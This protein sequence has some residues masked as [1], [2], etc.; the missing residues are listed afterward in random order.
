MDLG[1]PRTRREVP[2]GLAG[3]DSGSRGRTFNLSVFA[4]DG[5]RRPGE[6]SGLVG[7]KTPCKNGG[8]ADNKLVLVRHFCEVN[9]WL[10]L[11]FARYLLMI[12]SLMSGMGDAMEMWR[13][14]SG[15]SLFVRRFV[16]DRGP[17]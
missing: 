2:F 15:G 10:M 3:G 4:A 1:G 7:K 8:H 6:F 13:T 12:A 5:H 16:R 17:S 9:R 14:F 11:I